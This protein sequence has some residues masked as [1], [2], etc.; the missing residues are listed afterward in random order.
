MIDEQQAIH[1]MGQ[2]AGDGELHGDSK[3]LYRDTFIQVAQVDWDKA[4]R[5]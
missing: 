3:V 4:H 1:L 2:V 5:K